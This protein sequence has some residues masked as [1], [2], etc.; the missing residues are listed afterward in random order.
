MHARAPTH[1]CLALLAA[2]AAQPAQAATSASFKVSA[3]IVAGCH[4]NPV[5]AGNDASLGDLG[6]LDFGRHPANGASRLSIPLTPGSV[7][8]HCT[9]GMAPHISID[10][11]AHAQGG[12]RHLSNGSSLL[13]YR[14]YKDAALQQEILLSNAIAIT[15]ASDGRLRLSLYASTQLDGRQPA[16]L[17]QDVLTVTLTW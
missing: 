4:V 13:A 14:L 16:G 7:A 10:A 1:C 11:G 3:R 12:R 2:L 17:Y 6:S 5:H 15:P 9:P 8:L